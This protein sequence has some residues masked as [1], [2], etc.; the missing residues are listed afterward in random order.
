MASNTDFYSREFFD[1]AS[2]NLHPFTPGYRQ[3]K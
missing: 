1:A 3:N 2:D